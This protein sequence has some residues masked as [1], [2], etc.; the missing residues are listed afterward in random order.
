MEFLLKKRY[1]GVVHSDGDVLLLFAVVHRVGPSTTEVGVRLIPLKRASTSLIE[2]T[3]SKS[4]SAV[5]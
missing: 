2:V 4:T 5:P 1:L 3:T